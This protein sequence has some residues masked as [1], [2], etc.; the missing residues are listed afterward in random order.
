MAGAWALAQQLKAA[1]VEDPSP[2]PTIQNLRPPQ[3]ASAALCTWKPNC[4]KIEAMA[5]SVGDRDGYHKIPSN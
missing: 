1:L 5:T 3:P 4:P 2:T